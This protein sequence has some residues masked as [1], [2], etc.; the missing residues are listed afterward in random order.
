M[1]DSAF[2]KSLKAS[3]ISRGRLQEELLRV[4]AQAL[5]I[6][7]GFARADAEQHVVRMGIGF[8]QVVDVV[9]AD[10]RQT[11]IAR[12]SRQAAI[13]GALLLD[14]VP[15]HLEKKVIGAQDVAV[16]R[17]RADRPFL[18]LVRWASSAT[19]PLRQLLRPISP[20]ACAASSSL[21]MRG[22]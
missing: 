6:A 20:F 8:A 16:R 19:S 22:L 9:G 18:L 21:S 17:G 11:Q 5:R 10:E 7:E 3:A 4:V 14:P 13:H 1:F 15:L 12:D 2:G